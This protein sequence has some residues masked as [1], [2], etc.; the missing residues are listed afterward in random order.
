MNE[1]VH[2]LEQRINKLESDMK[3]KEALIQYLLG[4]VEGVKTK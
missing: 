4:F 2:E 3:Q 1:K